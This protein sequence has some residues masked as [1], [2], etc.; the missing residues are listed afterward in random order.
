VS[1]RLAGKLPPCVPYDSAT[2]DDL[3]ETVK[4]VEETGQK[5]LVDVVD[6]V[7]V[8]DADAV[9]WL[10]SEESKIVT[11]AAISID[12]GMTQY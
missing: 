3:S 12:Q 7:D 8:R 10:A 2:P 5:I 1:G 9:C 4:L 6:V 11:A